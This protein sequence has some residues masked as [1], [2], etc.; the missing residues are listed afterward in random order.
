MIICKKLQEIAL[1]AF[2]HVKIVNTFTVCLHRV[3]LPVCHIKFYVF[4]LAM[5][6]F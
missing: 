6:K 2:L 1:T 3:C 4:Y 5:H